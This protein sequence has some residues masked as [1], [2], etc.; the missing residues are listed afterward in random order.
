MDDVGVPPILE[1]FHHMTSR[2]LHLAPLFAGAWFRQMSEWLVVAQ[3]KPGV[4][5]G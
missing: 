2:S 5:A 1:N 4:I 3:Q